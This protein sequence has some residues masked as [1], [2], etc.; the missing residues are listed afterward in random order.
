MMPMADKTITAT[1]NN[2]RKTKKFWLRFEMLVLDSSA[3][4][5]ETSVFLLNAF[6]WLNNVSL[7][8]LVD[9]DSVIYAAFVAH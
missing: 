4:L 7:D 9:F 3:V 8:S 6:S 2:L 1:T 5:I